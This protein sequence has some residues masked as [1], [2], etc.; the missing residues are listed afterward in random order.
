MA[1]AVANTLSER[2]EVTVIC[3]RPSYDPA[4]RRAWRLWQTEYAAHASH[5][6]TIKVIR[7]GSTDYPRAKMGRR[8]FN[9]LS[10][11]ALSIPRALFEKCDLVLGMT[12]PPFQGIVAAFVAMLKNK[13]YVYNIR[14]LYPEMA[15]GGDIVKAGVLSRLWEVLH[16]WALRRA[17]RVVVL[18]EDM[19]RRILAKRLPAERVIVVRDGSSAETQTSCIDPSVVQKIRGGYPFVVLHAGNLGFYGA[20][21]TIVHSARDL[22]QDGVGF[23]FVGEGAQQEQVRAA[24]NESKNV[25]LLPF[26]DASQIPSVT[27]AGDLHVV[28]IRR[29]L[30][31]VIVPSK[32]YGILTAGKPILAVAPRE[33]DIVALG[34][35]DGFAVWANPDDPSQVAEVIRELVRDRTRL[36]NMAASAQRAAAGYD[37]VNELRKFAQ[38]IEEAHTE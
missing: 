1:E 8:I 14:D 19:R 10:Y 4:E 15:V 2:H 33:T 27:A 26:F 11:V 16:R 21:R 35:R 12:D 13:P 38:T 5:G 36:K 32:M 37:R 18:G 3:G 23:V 24:A 34:E 31:G 6:A 9:Y 22:E 17:R 29:G 7:V 20:W 30:E 25:R 28:T